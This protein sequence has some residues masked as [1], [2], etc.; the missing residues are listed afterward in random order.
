MAERILKLSLVL[1]FFVPPLVFVPG[2]L[3]GQWVFMNYREPKLAA[4][5]IL[6]WLFMTIF[7]WTVWDRHERIERLKKVL[8]DKL[9][10]FF[11]C[12]F[13][14][15]C[16]TVR[17]AF[18]VEASFY[19]LAQYFTIVNLF[20]ALSVLWQEEKIL[21]LSL[22][23]I[24][25]A[26]VIVTAIGLYQFWKPIAWLIPIANKLACNPST[27]GYKNPAAQAVLGQI[28]LLLA[29]LIRTVGCRKWVLAGAGIALFLI[30][31]FYLSTLQSRTSYFAFAVTLVF[32]TAMLTAFLI[33]VRKDNILRVVISV[34]ILVSVIFAA[35]L[36][37]YPP[38]HKRFDMMMVY[39]KNPAKFLEC[40]RGIYLR[41]SIYMAEKNFFGVGIGNWGFAYPVYRHYKPKFLFNKFIQVRRAHGDYAQML[42]ETGFP[43]LL[44][45]LIL[46]GWLFTRGLKTLFISRNL[47]DMLILA[48]MFTFMFIMLFD[49][50]IEMPYH[51]FAFFSVLILINARFL[52][53]HVG[54][55]K[56]LVKHD[57]CV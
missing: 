37:K 54:N 24:V 26:F 6:S 39:F 30:E 27:M 19:E 38:A 46:I 3:D 31:A 45:F 42:G 17:N 8:Q 36:I 53:V 34:L 47:F 43:G 33:R 14:Y 44:L 35:T 10:W 52:N 13:I 28:F 20:I 11:I 55:R 2:K 56:V 16:W 57:Q 12:F 32:T 51:K 50:C 23:S 25:A 15:L 5:Q 41:N 7:W 40:D 9:T 1:L 49:Y 48:Q 18:V 21:L 4:V 29:L 22:W